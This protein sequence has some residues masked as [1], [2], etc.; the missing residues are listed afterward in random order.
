MI[1]KIKTQDT[2]GRVKVRYEKEEFIHSIFPLEY[3][4][5]NLISDSDKKTNI[6]IWNMTSDG[7]VADSITEHHLVSI[8]SV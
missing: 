6:I 5:D 7:K 4:K 3:S 8:E 2:L 1:Y